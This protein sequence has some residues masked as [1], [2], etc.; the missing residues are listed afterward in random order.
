M[1]KWVLGHKISPQLAT[2]DY[3]L[4]FGESPSHTPG[5]PPH[6][7]NNYH[8]VF[9]V[10]EGEMEFIINGK[11]TVIRQGESINLPPKTLH[12]FSN[13]SSKVCKWVNIHSPKGFLRF[14]D[15]LGVSIDELDAMNK[16]IDKT[17]LDR[18]LATAADYDMH[19]KL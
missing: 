18:V 14:F 6:H 15:N 13:N 7:H 5:P 3:D 17:I 19:I 2:G 1:T 10:A 12:T 8:E 11:K 16:S 4:V 9:L